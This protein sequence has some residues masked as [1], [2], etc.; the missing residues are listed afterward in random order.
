MNDQSKSL[1]LMIARIN[2]C[3]Q[4]HSLSMALGVNK[5]YNEAIK[6][7]IHYGSSESI[8]QLRLYSLLTG[9]LRITLNDN[10]V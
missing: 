2:Q 6:N 7:L 9:R 1:S 5:D 4:V 10:D 8:I 3:K